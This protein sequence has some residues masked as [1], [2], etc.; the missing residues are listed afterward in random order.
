ML[1]GSDGSA[2]RSIQRLEFG[3]LDLR[4]RFEHAAGSTDDAHRS[5]IIEC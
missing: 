5:I 1:D 2:Q 4:D 3:E